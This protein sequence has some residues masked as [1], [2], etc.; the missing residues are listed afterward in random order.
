MSNQ[1]TPTGYDPAPNGRYNDP[2]PK[3]KLA[4]TTFTP[5]AAPAT[6]THQAPTHRA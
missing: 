4:N 5:P 3:T 1:P 2:H 6:K